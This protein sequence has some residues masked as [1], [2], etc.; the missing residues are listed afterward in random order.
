MHTMTT[1]N[2][3][4]TL[5]SFASGYER[6]GG[7]SY[8]AEVHDPELG[9]VVVLTFP[10]ATPSTLFISSNGHKLISPPIGSPS[11]S[12]NDALAAFRTHRAELVAAFGGAA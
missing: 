6:S 4:P 9:V 10:E 7:R 1:P 5:V 8:F 3:E 12:P 11:N 2:T